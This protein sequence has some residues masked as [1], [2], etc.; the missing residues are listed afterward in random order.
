MPI[1]KIPFS[2]ALTILIIAT[3]A[4]ALVSC[5][6][7][8]KDHSSTQSI[9]KS[10]QKEF[11]DILAQSDQS[12]KI[13]NVKTLDSLMGFRQLK[14]ESHKDSFNLSNFSQNRKADSLF[15]I[16]YYESTL[17]IPFES[18]H[19][20]MNLTLCFYQDT[21]IS[22]SIEYYC[23]QIEIAQGECDPPITIID[24]ITVF[25][26]FDKGTF[27]KDEKMKNID[28]SLIE[29]RASFSEYSS[30]VWKGEIVQLVYT[31]ESNLHADKNSPGYLGRFESTSLEY[32]LISKLKIIED[33]HEYTKQ[34]NELNSQKEINLSNQEKSRKF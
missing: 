25:S 21:L 19:Y 2:L 20:P 1:Q 3:N 30:F 32:S 31:H 13:G 28:T 29:I 5:E 9:E 34:I 27:S 10:S 4:S 24:L 6:G 18:K 7:G 11:K 16:E 17:N 8:D 33:Y 14:L 15:D 12:F 22:F 26:K 23:D